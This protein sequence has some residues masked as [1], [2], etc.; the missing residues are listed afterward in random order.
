MRPVKHKTFSNNNGFKKK[1]YLNTVSNIF[2]T[3]YYTLSDK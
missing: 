1:L 3:Y 2:Y